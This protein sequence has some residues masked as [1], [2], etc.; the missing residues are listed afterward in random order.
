[1]VTT[2]EKRCTLNDILQPAYIEGLAKNHQDNG[3]LTVTMDDGKDV[4]LPTRMWILNGIFLRVYRTFAVPIDSSKVFNLTS[5]NDETAMVCYNKI[6]M[7]LVAKHYMTADQKRMVF[8]AGHTYIDLTGSPVTTEEDNYNLEVLREIF[9]GIAYYA[10]FIHRFMRPYQGALDV[11]SLSRLFIQKPLQDVIHPRISDELG[12]SVA[13][14]ILDSANQAL[15][16]VLSDKEGPLKNNILLPYMSTKLLKRNQ[17]PQMFIAYGCRSDITDEMK[18]HI[19]ASCAMSGHNGVE[20]YAIEALSAKKSAF[21]NSEVIER[22]QYFARKCRL[23]GSQLPRIYT[24]PC[25]SDVLIDMQIP[26]KYMANF[27]GKVIRFK[28]K[29]VILTRENIRKYVAEPVHMYS[30]FGCRHTDGVCNRCAGYMYGRLSNFVPPGIHIGVFSATKAV[31]AITQ[32]ILSAKHLIR[33]LSKEYNIPVKAMKYFLKHNDG[34]VWNAAVIDIFERM[35]IRI[36]QDAIGTVTDLNQKMLPACE[37]FSKIRYF[38][39]LIDDKVVERVIM[40]DGT[41]IPYLSTYA[42]QFMKKN[43]K[44]L[45]IGLEDI[46][47][48]MAGYDMHRPFMKYTVMNDDMVSFVNRIENF[49]S[50]QVVNYNHIPTL[51]KDFSTILYSKTGIEIFYVEMLLRAFMISGPDDY[52][53]PVID[54]GNQDVMFGKISSVISEA[55][56][57]TKLSFERID[58]LFTD[59]KATLV[60][61]REGMNDRYFGF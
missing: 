52:S 10:N 55:A 12:T 36:P 31:A 33:T 32:L 57:S 16:V 48:P 45:E 42:L 1:M 18:R 24:E 14:K 60:D 11:L 27:I 15:H 21:F 47:I 56:L 13:E 19:I 39:V 22:A 46:T 6:Y 50:T 30:P 51:L 25:G 61:M 2:M 49:L 41:A 17:L 54:D 38:D 20:D 40:D 43:F 4:R 35:K 28:G 29:D 26:P 34:I 44:N 23:V 53:I 3:Y 58:G 5:L 7:F 59:P 37:S 9:L 8:E